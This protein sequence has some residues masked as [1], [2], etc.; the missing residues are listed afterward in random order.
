MVKAGLGEYWINL[1]MLNLTRL[2]RHLSGSIVQ[3]VG[4]MNLEFR[5][6]NTHSVGYNNTAAT[7][8]DIEPANPKHLAPKLSNVQNIHQHIT[9][10]LL[11]GPSPPR[12][13]VTCNRDCILAVETTHNGPCK[14]SP[15]ISI[16]KVQLHKNSSRKQ[17][18]HLSQSQ[19]SVKIS[20]KY[21]LTQLLP[22]GR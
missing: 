9:C 7:I 6:T 2:F 16:S 8:I 22:S 20:S 3:A 12:T 21:P 19:L 10:S 4:Y 14:Y 17:T 18:G 5:C 13:G 1:D 15:H 11:P